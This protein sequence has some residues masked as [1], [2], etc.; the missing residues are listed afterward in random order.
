[1]AACSRSS[2]ASSSAVHG[3]FETRNPYAG[4]N[5]ARPTK[6]WGVTNLAVPAV[7]NIILSEGPNQLSAVLNGK[8]SHFMAR[9]N[10]QRE[11][12]LLKSLGYIL[13]Y[14]S[15]SASINNN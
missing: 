13:E 12:T 5:A 7:C 9:K 10:K 11:K 15:W 6:V 4:I 3:A 2:S 1:M 8:I 14:S